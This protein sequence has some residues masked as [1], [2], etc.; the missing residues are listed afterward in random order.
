[1]IEMC[2]QIF[3]NNW[4]C[5][6]RRSVEKKKMLIKN[7]K[8]KEQFEE[9]YRHVTYDAVMKVGHLAYTSNS[10]RSKELLFCKA[11]SVLYSSQEVSQAQR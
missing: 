11:T 4:C 6:Y 5:L 8:Q 10:I 7:P 1:M 2:L 3:R 9:L